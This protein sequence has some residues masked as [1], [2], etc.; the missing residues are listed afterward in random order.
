MYNTYQMK[1]L[2]KENYYEYG[3]GDHLVI[4]NSLLSHINPDEGG[5]VEKLRIW[6]TEREEEKTVMH[7]EKGK[8]L[9]KYMENP[10]GFTTFEGSRPSDTICQ[11]LDAVAAGT[12]ALLFRRF[13]EVP[14]ENVVS[15]ARSFHWN[16]RYGDDAIMKNLIKEG[17]DYWEFLGQSENKH[18]LAPAIREALKGMVDSLNNSPFA[19]WLHDKNVQHEV[20]VS[21]MFSGDSPAFRNPL[22]TPLP[23]KSLIDRL[24]VNHDKKEICIE[25][26]KTTREPVSIFFGRRGVGLNASGHAENLYFSGPFYRFRYYRQHAFYE[27]MLRQAYPEYTFRHRVIPVET[28]PPYECAL[29]DVD[30]AAIRAGDLEIL[31]CMEAIQAYVS[32]YVKL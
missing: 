11:I 8:L 7:L 23:A 15:A 5:S 24:Q 32:K 26:L 25:E 16:D 19:D 13:T 20:A 28:S 6:L 21:G 2:T 3:D 4:S 1:E 9:H 17:S 10:R 29:Y 31:G 18:I 14:T 30:E 27:A 22:K 12:P